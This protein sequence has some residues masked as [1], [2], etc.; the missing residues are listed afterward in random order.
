MNQIDIETVSCNLCGSDDHALAHEIQGFRVVRCRGCNLVFLN[1]RPTAKAIAAI[2]GDASYHSQDDGSETLP[3]G[4][5]DYLKLREHLRFAADELLRPLKGA[6][7]GTLLDV[8][9]AMGVM[10][11]RYRE[12]GWTAYGVDASPFAAAYARDTLGLDVFTGTVDDVGLQPGSVDLVTSSLVIEHLADPM[13]TLYKL[14][15]LVRP[16]GTIITATHD[17]SGLWPRIIGSRWR[18]YEIPEHLYYFSRRTLTRMLAEAGFETFKVTEPL[19]MA[20]AVGAEPGQSQLYA[21]IRL[22]RAA[23]LMNAAAPR[24]RSFELITG[25]TGCW[26][27]PTVLRST[28]AR[29]SPGRRVVNRSCGREVARRRKTTAPKT[30]PGASCLE[31]VR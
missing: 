7:P 1:P 28:P 17:V 18:H 20:A 31:F 10:L 4:Y 3:S 11:E 15:A 5:Q 23:G 24:R 16:G 25:S 21:P 19:T 26:A 8:G 2:Y 14:H 27:G 9:C 29:S 22:L 13:G 6:T 12:H 30:R